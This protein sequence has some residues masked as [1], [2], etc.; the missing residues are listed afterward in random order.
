MEGIIPRAEAKRLAQYI[1]HWANFSLQVVTNNKNQ[2]LTIIA[3]T[4]LNPG[5]GGFVAT[6]RHLNGNLNNIYEITQ[7]NPIDG[8]IMFTSPAIYEQLTSP[9]S[10]S[11][12]TLA[13]GSIL[14]QI[15]AYDDMY[16]IVGDSGAIHGATSRG[17]VQFTNS[18]SYHLNAQGVQ[19][20]VIAFYPT[21]QNNIALSNQAILVKVLLTA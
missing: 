6:L 5:G 7:I 18:L 10:V 14:G 3:A 16:T 9:V 2:D 17:Y 12:I 1:F 21:N 13:S 19:E 8:N 15:V 11:G 20:G 4:N